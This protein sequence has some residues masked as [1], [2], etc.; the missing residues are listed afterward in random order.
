MGLEV[1]QKCQNKEISLE[2]FWSDSVKLKKI[3]K[4]SETHRKIANM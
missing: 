2:N 3:S 1:D 4:A